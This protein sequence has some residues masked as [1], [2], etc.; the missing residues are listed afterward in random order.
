[1]IEPR[2][3]RLCLVLVVGLLS[4]SGDDLGPHVPAAVVV[5][6][7][8]PQ[9]PL[10]GTFQ[11]SATVMDAAGQAIPDVE[12]TFR[13][14][15]ATVLTVDGTGLLA[16]PGVLGH[17]LIVAA[18]GEITT[19]VDAAVVL[20]A[21]AMLVSKRVLDLDTG[22]EVSVLVTVSDENSQ[23]VP[24]PVI[25]VA[26]TNPAIARA[27][28]S[29]TED[30]VLLVTGLDAGTAVIDLSSGGHT[31]QIAVTVSQ[32]AASAVVTPSSLL[33][34]SASGTQQAIASLRD[35][36]GDGMLPPGPFTWASSDESVAVVGATGIVT[37]VGL[38]SAVITAT[39][40]MFAGRLGVFVGTPPAGELL[41][42]VPFPGAYGL[43]VTSDGR[44]FVTGLTTFA[45]GALP[46]FAF[47]PRY[48]TVGPLLD[49]AVLTSFDRA[50]VARQGG[51]VGPAVVMRGLTN[52]AFNTFEVGLGLP[53]ATEV[54]AD[55]STLLVG[56][57]DGFEF[58]RL[59]FFTGP[60]VGSAVG[61]IEKVTRDPVNP[62]FHASGS[63]GVFE[64]EATAG[65]ITRRFRV[66]PGSHAVS[67]DGERLYTVN[68]TDGIRV[69]NLDTGAQGPRLGSVAGTD[70]T[71]T[72]DGRFLYLIHGS[73]EIAGGSR[74]Y[75]VDRVSGALLRE[76]VLG[77]LARRVEVTGDGT[78][79][80]TNEGEFQG[81]GWVDFVR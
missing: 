56:T 37:P 60:T 9:V 40:D 7:A 20:P 42:R 66:G 19:E 63:D 62:V 17:S 14:T 59:P 80:I 38:G 50:Y 27:E 15:D 1:M 2:P 45:A 12:V 78:A 35:R 13:S 58:W 75:I 81:D 57:T 47:T 71:V 77:G 46:D 26:S 53:L 28:A 72:P 36:T 5:T 10:S 48:E 29:P 21:S 3:V 22:E 31:A 49:V 52:D 76:V 16:S 41:A 39:S 30:G 64:V 73:S 79:V 18:A 51:G 6:P 61:R 25:I 4:C 33:F 43:A 65:R 8:A 68:P 74:L 32:Y 54:S 69:W 23:P 34:P 24:D 11:L 67:P 70:L 55:D 44:Y